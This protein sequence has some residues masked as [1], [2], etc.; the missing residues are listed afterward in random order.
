MKLKA[1][2]PALLPSSPYITVKDLEIQ[3]IKLSKKLLEVPFFEAARGTI[4]GIYGPSGVGK[5]LFLQTLALITPVQ[6][7]ILVAGS[8]HFDQF[9]MK[10]PLNVIASKGLNRFR[11]R[12][13]AFIQQEPSAT[14]NP[15][16]TI[17]KHLEDILRYN[18]TSDVK[19]LETLLKAVDL[20]DLDPNRFPQ[21]YSGGQL[22]RYCAICAILQG[23]E[24]LL[25]DE[26]TASLDQFQ[27]ENFLGIL[28]SLAKEFN[29]CVLIVSHD[30]LMLKNFCDYLYHF[31]YDGKV[32]NFDISSSGQGFQ[33][34]EKSKSTLLD[35]KGLYYSYKNSDS[36]IPAIQDLNLTFSE[37]SFNAIIGPSGC[38]KS[39]LSHILTG[40]LTQYT[41]DI[42]WRGK[43]WQNMSY[44][45]KRLLLASCSYIPQ[46]AL[47]S[48]NPAYSV[49]ELVS[50]AIRDSNNSS[51]Q[52]LSLEKGCAKLRLD[53]QYLD[54]YAY[55]LSG[56]ERQRVNIA[57]ALIH[58]PA[59]CIFD[60]AMS[61]IDEWDKPHFMNWVLS[62]M[63]DFESTMIW[64]THNFREL[65]DLFDQV[66]VMSNGRVVE[67]GTF[68]EISNNPKS[69]IAKMLFKS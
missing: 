44:Q 43:N 38:G 25:C 9:T 56:G 52:G 42:Y 21:E 3:S 58:K 16:R 45:D 50:Q 39:T 17:K 20:H 59:L 37:K 7:D 60:E 14:F 55:Q 27:K 51:F 64:I 46:D 49:A 63:H 35:I 4:T 10:F 22:Q 47:L 41:G 15:N 5:S 68:N 69:D 11:Q 23:A 24:M 65:H 2:A 61:G 13:I 66:V 62:L 8:V 19:R 26:P 34:I 30:Q 40:L 6:S 31:E 67:V 28:K 53:S 36:C 29:V 54:K 33:N 12:R 1:V 57:R 32:A 48:L 18:H